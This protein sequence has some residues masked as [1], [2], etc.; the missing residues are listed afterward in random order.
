M[1]LA[2]GANL[3]LTLAQIAGGL[4]AGSL[5]LVADAIHNLS[6]ALSLVIALAARRIARRPASAAMTFGYGRAGAVAALVNYTLLA[7][8]GA[9]LAVEACL[10]LVDP[11]PVV[12]WVVVAVAAV[13]LAV[14][15]AT[16]RLTR[17]MAAGSANMR[18]A[19]L[20]NLADALGSIAV[21]VSGVLVILYDWRLVDPLLT[22]AI[23]AYVLWHVG[24]DAG[25]VVRVL[26]LGSPPDVEVDAVLDAIAEVEGVA[27]VHHLHLWQLDERRNALD[28]HVTIEA[29]QWRRADA[30][31][32]AVK[33][34]LAQRFAV[35]HTTIELECAAHACVRPA[36]VG[37]D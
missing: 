31:K 23:A 24:R 16:V 4:F 15:V 17:P 35:A 3:A 10:G 25:G 19:V 11:Q 18:A 21:L 14:D 1:A 2:V 8:I 28:A 29:G 33:R 5:A 30:V 32:A 12:G 6:D 22:L 13:A 34:R 9:W 7:A 37:A 26:M 27:D 20:H 36:R